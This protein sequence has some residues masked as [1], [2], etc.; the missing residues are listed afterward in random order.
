MANDLNGKSVIVTGAANGIGLACAR[1]F[2]KAGASVVMADIDEDKLDHEADSLNSEGHDGTATAFAGDLREKLTMTNLM[3]A[4]LDANENIH[5]L[6][7]AARMLVTGDPLDP[8]GT[9]LEDV[10]QQNVVANLRLSQIVARRMIE[11]AKEEGEDASDRAIVNLSSI[12]AQRS[13]PQLFA[14]SVASAALD[15][16]TRGLAVPLSVHGI[17]VNAVAVG[18]IYGNSLGKSLPEVE[19][20]PDAIRE[21][22]P[23]GRLG[24]FS[25]VADSIMFLASPLSRFTTGQVLTVDGG[26]LLIDPLENALI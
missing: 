6:V 21:V 12:F 7:N 19:D 10:L 8:A 18:G 22:V 26:R 2:M 3:A 15:Q 20:L 13:L 16:I 24:E 23:L 5:V 11:A 17:R 25:E 1:Q 9:A 4:T 14:F